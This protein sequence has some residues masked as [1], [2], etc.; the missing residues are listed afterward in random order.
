MYIPSHFE[1]TRP[2]VLRELMSQ[3]P[4]GALVVV[5]GGELVVNVWP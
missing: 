4:L 3:H 2:I 5:G 1:E